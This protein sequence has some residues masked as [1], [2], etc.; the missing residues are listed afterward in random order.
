M[1]LHATRR[2][3]VPVESQEPSSDGERVNGLRNLLGKVNLSL[4]CLEN[5]DPFLKHEE[6]GFCFQRLTH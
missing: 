6:E 1:C 2:S 4:D 5:I 3:I